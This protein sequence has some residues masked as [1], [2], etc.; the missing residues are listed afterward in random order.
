MKHA[1][2]FMQI[3][4]HCL[5]FCFFVFKSCSWLYLFKGS[6]VPVGL[7]TATLQQTTTE[8]LHELLPPHPLRF[9]ELFV[10]FKHL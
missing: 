8:N 10:C 1:A 3:P 9:R 5:C 2:L 7:G 4:V 6:Y